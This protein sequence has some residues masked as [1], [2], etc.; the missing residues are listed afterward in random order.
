MYENR[1][2][3]PSANRNPKFSVRLSGIKYDGRV[4]YIESVCAALIE[5]RFGPDSSSPFVIDRKESPECEPGVFCDPGIDGPV[6]AYAVLS[7]SGLA[8][9]YMADAVGRELVQTGLTTASVRGQLRSPSTL[10]RGSPSL[11]SKHPCLHA[12]ENGRSRC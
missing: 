3:E 6:P 11:E 7:D 9:R 8:R 4:A 12:V 2:H 5:S 10:G 1:I